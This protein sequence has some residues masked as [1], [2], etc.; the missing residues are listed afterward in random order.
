MCLAYTPLS[1]LL[2]ALIM[3]ATGAVTSRAS[4]RRA[5]RL[6]AGSKLQHAL[7]IVQLQ[8]DSLRRAF[9]ATLKA[10]MTPVSGPETWQQAYW[11]EAVQHSSDVASTVLKALGPV[12]PP[13]LHLPFYLPGDKALPETSLREPCNDVAGA[14]S[15]DIVFPP[16][17]S[18]QIYVF[19]GPS[20][21]G[22]K[23]GFEELMEEDAE[24]CDFEAIASE[25]LDKPAALASNTFTQTAK[26]MS[27]QLF[28]ATTTGAREQSL[29]RQQ[30]TPTQHTGAGYDAKNRDVA[31]ASDAAGCLSGAG[32][33]S[34]VSSGQQLSYKTA[35]QDSALTRQS[36]VCV[37]F[38]KGIC[39]QGEACRFVHSQEE[40]LEPIPVTS[41]KE[42]EHD[43]SNSDVANH[44]DVAGCLSGTGSNSNVSSEQQLS[45]ETA[46]QDAA[47]PPS[48]RKPWQVFEE[49]LE[50]QLIDCQ[51][52]EVT[53]FVREQT[54]AITANGVLATFNDLPDSQKRTYHEVSI[55]ELAAYDHWWRLQTH[56]DCNSFD[57]W[58]S[59]D[60]DA[61]AE[62]IPEDPRESLKAGKRWSALL[63][64]SDLKH[65]Q[66]TSENSIANKSAD[67]R[68]L[69][70]YDRTRKALPSETQVRAEATA[71]VLRLRQL[72]YC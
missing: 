46:W 65:D 38:R 45:Y 64:L 39:M 52:G 15:S 35:R 58:D 51:G 23:Y 26:A 56:N 7:F 29:T 14:R 18:K 37:F 20:L 69:A 9:A 42:T 53:D 27:A 22:P 40:L 71:H 3:A 59:L 70:D 68:A 2:A 55:K 19:S 11:S 4:Q 6:A 41:A 21:S 50:D 47:V 30:R 8:I 67:D 60:Q 28:R 5:L 63:A 13:G 16:M 32:S 48:I 34:I 33:D 10:T 17:P 1:P 61:K 62:C 12:G 36:K 66:G 57:A 44:V 49:D 31:N 54:T 24:N 72:A 43:A 25:S